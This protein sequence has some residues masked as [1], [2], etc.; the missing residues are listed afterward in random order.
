[1]A[2][3][4]KGDYNSQYAIWAVIYIPLHSVITNNGISTSFNI[5]ETK[6]LIYA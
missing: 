4:R 2:G 1:M 3:N 5:V 6:K